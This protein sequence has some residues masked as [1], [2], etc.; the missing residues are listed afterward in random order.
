MVQLVNV[1]VG[2]RLEL[3]GTAITR[4]VYDVGA[5]SVTTTAGTYAFSNVT[6]GNLPIGFT[7]SQDAATGLAVLTF[8]ADNT[9]QQATKTAG[10]PN[11][12]SYVWSSNGNFTNGTPGN[13]ETVFVASASIDDVSYVALSKLTETT[14]GGVTVVN[15]A[16][17]VGTVALSAGAQLLASA[18]TGNAVIDIGTVTGS[19]AL[20][21]ALGAHASLVD[22]AATDAGEVYLAQNG[23]TI[24]L[25]AAP[26]SDSFLQYYGASEFILRTPGPANAV[27]I[28]GLG[29]GATL[30]LPGARLTGVTF[31]A[32]SLTVVTDIGSYAFTN[33]TYS[34]NVT[35][36][37]ARHDAATNLESLT[38]D[39]FARADDFNRDGTADQL[40]RTTGGTLIDY[41]MAN[42][43]ITSAAVVGSLDATYRFLAAGDFNGDGTADQLWQAANGAIL[44]YAMQGGS[45]V[46][47]AVV[48]SLGAGYTF[49]AA[50]DFNG[51]GTTDQLWQAATGAIIDYTMLNGA[52]AN[53]A[54]VGTLDATYKF[55][56]VGDFNGDGVA[57]QLWQAANGALIDYGMVNATITSANVI[58]SA[59]AGMKFLA[60]ADFD[61]DGT[62]D[63]LFQA[64]NGQISDMTMRN[65]AVAGTAAVGTLDATWTFLSASDMNG[66]GTAD[67]LWQT[68][69]GSLVDFTMRNGSITDGTVIGALDGS[70]KFLA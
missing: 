29:A 61:G 37:V 8:G 51:D 58:G 23:G 46:S 1:E 34:G 7:S 15:A 43:S 65:G 31:G 50:G 25:A 40:W 44:D 66:D 12:G 49:L 55:L 36:F 52:I 11:A 17:N 24:D 47:S 6:Y 48:G 3:P 13:G 21:S 67:Q 35:G 19:G 14:T 39:T 45:I 26:S 53:G 60:A 16:L 42:G 38:F 69:A 9:F 54:V 57:D 27:A 32:H 64:A 20:L 4:V 41:G 28:T 18:T 62:A 22:F 33:V 68:S 10:G 59:A 56:G 70:F 63:L 5:F 30:E 2:D